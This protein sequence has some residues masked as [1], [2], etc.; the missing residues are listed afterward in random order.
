MAHNQGLFYLVFRLQHQWLPRFLGFERM[1]LKCL[2]FNQMNQMAQVESEHRMIPSTSCDFF[3][4]FVDWSV[5]LFDYILPC[6]L[7]FCNTRF[8]QNKQKYFMQKEEIVQK[9]LLGAK[10][11]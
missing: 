5:P 8:A 2:P 10:N 7:A 4:L 11:R 9:C 1:S 3:F 6:I